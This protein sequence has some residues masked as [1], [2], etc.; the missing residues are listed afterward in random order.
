MT[1]RQVVLMDL[2]LAG[3]GDVPKQLDSLYNRL[4]SFCREH[5]ID[6]HMSGLTRALLSFK[7]AAEYPVGTQGRTVAI[8]FGSGILGFMLLWVR[9]FRIR[10][11]VSPKWPGIRKS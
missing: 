11:L 2:G 1:S 9:V 8:G 7:K 10:R 4:A 3:P 5:S 6:L